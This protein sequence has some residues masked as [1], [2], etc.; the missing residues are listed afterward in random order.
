MEYERLERDDDLRAGVLFANGDN[1][2]AGLD[3]AEVGPRLVQGS[4]D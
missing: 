1:F 2:T 3:L 4:L